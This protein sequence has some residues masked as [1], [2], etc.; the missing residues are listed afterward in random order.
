L[1]ALP[2]QALPDGTVFRIDGQDRSPV[3]GGCARHDRACADERFLVGDGDG[4]APTKGDQARGKSDQ[5]GGRKDHDVRLGHV[6]QLGER[7]APVYELEIGPLLNLGRSEHRDRVGPPSLHLPL[8]H[9]RPVPGREA[10][11]P[12]AFDSLGG[13]PM[14]P[15]DDVQC[16]RPDRAGAAENDHTPHRLANPS[17]SVMYQNARKLDTSRPSMRSR[18][19][20]CPGMTQ[21][22]SLAPRCRLM[23]DSMRSPRT[24]PRA[25]TNPRA[26]TRK[27]SWLQTAPATAV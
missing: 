18:S 2:P 3:L 20:P 25:M 23:T 16:L 26:N 5:S 21:P 9:R 11:D 7:I 24:A 14:K 15:L 27:P 1:D 13:P 19:P 12:K 6:D 8:E 22:E 10:N 4:L 17:V